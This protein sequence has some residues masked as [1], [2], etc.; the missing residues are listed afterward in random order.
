VRR[1]K[2]IAL[3]SLT[4]NAANEAIEV[5][6]AGMMIIPAAV[7]L[8]GVVAA[9]GC[10]TFGLG[11]NVLPQVFNSMPG[12][13]FFG[14]LFFLLLFIGAITSAIS[15]TQP[16][17]AFVEEF[18]N[19]SRAQSVSLIA[20]L[21]GVGSLIVIWFTDGLL[22]LDTLDFW[23]GT[24]S[25]YVSSSLFLIVF[26]F[27]WGTPSGLAELRSGALAPL[28]RG[29]AFLINW[30]TPAIMVAIFLA[31]LYQ[32]LFVKQSYHITN[33]LDGKI[34]AILPMLWV[35]VVTIF[36]IVVAHTSRRF[37]HKNKDLET[38]YDREPFS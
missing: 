11:F 2:D 30:V 24:M 1:R 27:V 37:R 18:W 33:L 4:A 13:Q 17:V 31:W 20:M 7:A 23:L 16:S 12:G 10:G 6:L 5:G 19:L 21:L 35:A 29:I 26:R 25:L 28:G 9:A 15:I 14:T 22:A 34:G 32:N 3:S 36:F 38:R 8:L